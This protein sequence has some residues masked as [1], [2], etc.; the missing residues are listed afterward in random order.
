VTDAKQLFSKHT[1]VNL[2][3]TDNK[4]SKNNKVD[5]SEMPDCILA[6]TGLI[7]TNPNRT[8]QTQLSLSP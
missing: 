7:L 8:K 3:E 5:T 4:F 1:L 6:H 2:K